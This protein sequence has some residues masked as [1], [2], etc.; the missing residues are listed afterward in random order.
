MMPDL[1][2][3][4]VAR[5]FLLQVIGLGPGT[6]G[7][8]LPGSLDKRLAQKP[9]CIPSSVDPE[10]MTAAFGDRCNAFMAFETLI[11]I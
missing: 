11:G 10:L 1:Q 3:P 8:G 9:G 4:E 2:G 6:L 5:A 7:D